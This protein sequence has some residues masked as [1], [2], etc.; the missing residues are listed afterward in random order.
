VLQFQNPPFRSRARLPN[1]ASILLHF[2]SGSK[3][4]DP[5]YLLMRKAHSLEDVLW[6]LEYIVYGDRGR[7]LSAPPERRY[8]SV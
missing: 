8:A 5:K 4:V 2:D 7:S 1:M 6:L 3:P